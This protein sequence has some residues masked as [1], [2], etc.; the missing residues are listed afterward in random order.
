MLQTLICCKVT[1]II[2]IEEVKILLFD[3]QMV[4]FCVKICF[5]SSKYCV[6][7]AESIFIYSI[8]LNCNMLIYNLIK[9]GL[10]YSL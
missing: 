6:K 5:F 8:L 9:S 1:K 10:N 7:W 2:W 4:V 3:V